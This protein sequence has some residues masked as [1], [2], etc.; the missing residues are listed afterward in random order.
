MLCVARTAKGEA[1]LDGAQA[2]G[3]LATA[4]APVEE[5]LET[6][7]HQLTRAVRPLSACEPFRAKRAARL[8]T[9]CE[10]FHAKPGS[11]S[12]GAGVKPAMMV[13]RPPQVGLLSRRLA[14][15]VSTNTRLNSY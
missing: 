11:V 5:V 4:P 6:Q 13:R 15:K 10:P 7:P 14:H 3:R 8:F 12:R 1:L 9:A 2:A